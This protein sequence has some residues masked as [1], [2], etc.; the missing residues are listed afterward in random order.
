MAGQIRDNPDMLSWETLSYFLLMRVQAHTF[1]E[2]FDIDIGKAFYSISV[3]THMSW[4][5]QTIWH[6]RWYGELY[7]ASCDNVT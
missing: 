7:L 3:N 5:I 2:G 4:S 6:A 1:W